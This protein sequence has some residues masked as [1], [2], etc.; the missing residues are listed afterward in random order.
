MN[1]G[2]VNAWIDGRGVDIDAVELVENVRL[3]LDRHPAD[4][5]AVL[6]CIGQ[7]GFVAEQQEGSGLRFDPGIR[8]LRL[9]ADDRAQVVRNDP[10]LEKTLLGLDVVEQ[11]AGDIRCVESVLVEA[12][13][14]VVLLRIGQI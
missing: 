1:C 12:E 6:S 4:L 7:R 5:D 13:V 9:Y 2:L 10:S 14:Y 8:A 3:I 11:L